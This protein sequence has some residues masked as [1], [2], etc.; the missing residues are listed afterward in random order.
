MIGMDYCK[1]P[2]DGRQK[3]DEEKDVTDQGKNKFSPRKSGRR[4]VAST[5]LAAHTGV[6]T[7][8]VTGS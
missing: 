1:P 5:T 7:V 4:Y 8:T 6:N 3:E 2:E